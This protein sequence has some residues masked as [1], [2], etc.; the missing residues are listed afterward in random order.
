MDL[1]DK[2]IEYLLDFNLPSG[3][4]ASFCDSDDDNNDCDGNVGI[5]NVQNDNDTKEI[6]H[7]TT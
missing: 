1:N 5:L 2:D 3:S 4:K 6:E 7:I